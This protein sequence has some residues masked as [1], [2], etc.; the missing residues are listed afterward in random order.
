M[1][2]CLLLF[3]GF[4]HLSLTQAQTESKSFGLMLS[5]LLEHN[6]EEISVKE[7]FLMKDV[8]FLDV[9]EQNEFEVSH[10]NNSVWVGYNDFTIN[11]LKVSTNNIVIVYCSVGYRSEKIGQILSKEGYIKVYNLYGG[12]FE[13]VNQGY[14]VF[15]KSDKQTE[16]VHAFDS[17]WGLWLNKGTKVY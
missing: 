11:R 3:Y 17:I 4:L 1:K 6:V 5:K 8:V 9:R 16:K 10:I 15:D 13:W 2:K 12:I 7:A 14:P